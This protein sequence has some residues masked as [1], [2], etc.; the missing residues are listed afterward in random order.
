[1]DDQ[2]QL[3]ALCIYGSMDLDVWFSII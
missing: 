1:M 2:L 3:P